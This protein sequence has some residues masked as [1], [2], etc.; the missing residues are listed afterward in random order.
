V[1]AVGA[2]DTS[3]PVLRPRNVKAKE[4]LILITQD[5]DIVAESSLEPY[6]EVLICEIVNDKYAARVER[7]SARAFVI[8]PKTHLTAQARYRLTIA[9]EVLLG[10]TPE[11]WP[12]DAERFERF[13]RWLAR[14]YDRPALP[15]SLVDNFQ[16]PIERAL[17]QLDQSAP[18]VSLAF[19]RAVH[20]LRVNVPRHEQPP[21][22][23]QL[24]FLI[25]HDNLTNAELDALI[26]VDSAIR[27]VIDTSVISLGEPVIVTL[28]EIPAADYF[29]SRPLF[30]EYHTYNGDEVQGAKPYPRA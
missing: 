9:K 20:E 7:N 17:E 23:V 15:K 13:V 22:E 24:T 12:G 2:T 6:I 30:L 28:E 10:L 3:T 21:F 19:S 4:R 8:D 1:T 25:K 29:A 18:E 16:T 27:A 26:T 5:C 14:R 11:P